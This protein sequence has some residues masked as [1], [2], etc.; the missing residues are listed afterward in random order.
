MGLILALII[1]GGIPYRAYF[2]LGVPSLKY[3]VVLTRTNLTILTRGLRK[4]IREPS[5]QNKQLFMGLNESSHQELFNQSIF[6]LNSKYFK[7]YH[8]KTKILKI[9]PL[10]QKVPYFVTM[11]LLLIAKINY[12][13]RNTRLITA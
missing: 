8:G 2:F 5:N 9:Y 4:I 10:I 6:F 1:E 11:L 12:L 7:S 13:T 3:L